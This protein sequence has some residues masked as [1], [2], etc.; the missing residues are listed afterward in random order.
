MPCGWGGNRR[1]GVALAVR[2]RLQ[3]FIHLLAHGLRKGDEH[4]AYTPHGVWQSF[5]FFTRRAAGAGRTATGRTAANASSVTF[6]AVVEHRPA[7]NEI[8]R[9][10]AQ[11]SA[12]IDH[13]LSR[14]ICID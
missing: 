14:S 4:P 10:F 3:W 8:L 1:S 11:T 9:H 12:R 6:T 2:H 13:A 5:T 7:S